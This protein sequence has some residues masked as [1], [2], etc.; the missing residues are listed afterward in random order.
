MDKKR[1]WNDNRAENG[2]REGEVGGI[3]FL[4]YLYSFAK[5]LFEKNFGGAGERN[6]R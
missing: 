2:C 5:I 4:V 3:S 6:G 1:P